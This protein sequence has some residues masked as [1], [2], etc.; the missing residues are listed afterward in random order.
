MFES[1]ATNLF[2]SHSPH[3]LKV[4]G[5]TVEQTHYHDKQQISLRRPAELADRQ[6][7]RLLE[8]GVSMK[9]RV[10]KNFL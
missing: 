1:A 5:Q 4:R 8:F 9:R 10:Q 2:K 7:R 6:H 3:K